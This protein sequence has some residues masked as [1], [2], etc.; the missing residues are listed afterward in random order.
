MRVLIIAAVCLVGGYALGAR[1]ARP[2]AR[3]WHGRVAPQKAD[4]YQ[5]YLAEAGLSKLRAIPK[6]MG[7][8]MFRRDN[9]GET[10]FMVVS[11]WP[12]RAAIHAYA[13]EDI[14]KTHSLPRDPEYLLEVEPK[15]R[16]FDVVVDD[17]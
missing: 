5:R 6:N 12:D 14:E 8:Q 17:R 15:V 11:Y 16:H 3:I 2:V 9:P 10:E 4:E 13:G 7:V 1:E